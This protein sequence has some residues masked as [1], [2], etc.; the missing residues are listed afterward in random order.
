MKF[1][2]ITS[3]F[4]LASLT[5]CNSLMLGSYAGSY[6]TASDNASDRDHEVGVQ[7]YIYAYPMVMMEMT[8]RVS[9]N[10]EAPKGSFAPMNQFAHLRAFPDAS[11]REVV[12]PNADTLYSIAWFDLS[13]EPMILSV[14][15][16]ERYYMM[17]MLDMWTEVFA[18]PGSRTTGNQAASYAI[19]GPNW[20]HW[21]RQL[22]M[23]R[24]LLSGI[25]P[26]SPS[27]AGIS[28]GR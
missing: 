14:P 17:P 5:L 15:E 13:K 12:R 16:T 18:V 9:T 8:R 4:A 10:V 21:R 7:A 25:P 24:R 11:F 3:T 2:Q 6:A 19:H 26:V 20:E 22:S 1:K 23:H 27:M 28:Q